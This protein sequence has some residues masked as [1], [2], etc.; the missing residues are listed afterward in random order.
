MMTFL[1]LTTLLAQ[2][3][4]PSSADAVTAPTAPTE[5]ATAATEAIAPLPENCAFGAI[6]G[7][8]VQA[9]AQLNLSDPS[10]AWIACYSSLDAKIASSWH[11][12]A[13]GTKD[14]AQ[15]A[16]P[17]QHVIAQDLQG[18]E[19]HLEW[20][21]PN[22]AAPVALAPSPSVIGPLYTVK[23][24]GTDPSGISHLRLLVN[25]APREPEN[26]QS[27]LNA[28]AQSVELALEGE[29]AL[30]NQSHVVLAN[31]AFDA[32]GPHLSYR[33]LNTPDGAPLGAVGKPPYQLELTGADAHG[34]TQLSMAGCSGKE[35][36]MCQ[37]STANATLVGIDALGNRAEQ[38]ITL[39]VDST[40]PDF[41]VDDQPAPAELRLKVGDS[42]RFEAHD[43]AGVSKA[44]ARYGTRCLVMPTQYL[45]VAR[46][47]YRIVL[48]ASDA[49]GNSSEQTV[50]VQVQR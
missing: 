16:A 38:L 29:D 4:I 36:L 18:P 25:G 14:L 1:A 11:R 35:R 12:F 44:C 47:H 33:A 19:L 39:Q 49:F 48:K 43:A 6:N 3:E 41:R 9:R 37:L 45:A 17:L 32:E 27:E 7:Q 13:L 30:G 42:V 26:W 24:A 34:P 28:E 50:K 22:G 31:T 20:A 2:G 5:L 46:G 23:I 10:I 40:G 15:N 21:A 8:P